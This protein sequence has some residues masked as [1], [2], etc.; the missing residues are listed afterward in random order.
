MTTRLHTL[1]AAYLRAERAAA[2]LHVAS[3][4][5]FE[6][7]P[8]FD[9]DDGVF[10]LDEVRAAIGARISLL[11]RLRQ[12][13]AEV[14]FEVG[15]PL[16]VDDED[17]DIANHVA[18]EP[19][20][21]PGDH[22]AVMDVVTARYCELLD[23]SR[24]LW[25]L[26]FLTGEADGRVVLL[27]RIHH[28]VADGLGG[29]GLATV[30]LDLERHPKAHAYPELP[31]PED[32]PGTV[33]RVRS[34]VVDRTS[35]A[36]RLLRQAASTA[37]HHPLHAARR[38][39]ESIESLRGNGY[40]LFAP[41]SPLNAPLGDQRRLLFVRARLDAFKAIGEAH[42]ATVNDVVLA[43]VA[44]ATRSLLIERGELLTPDAFVKILVPVSFRPHG[45]ASGLGNQV[46]GFLVPLPIG[47]GDPIVRLDTIAG[48]MRT[49]KASGE[50]AAT[51]ALLE[52]ADLLPPVLL[53]GAHLLM[54][55]QPLVNFV[56]TNV[57]GPPCA[58]YAYGAE[59]LD[60]FPIVPL[61]GNLTL[62]VAVLSYNGALNF[63]LT[64]DP[65]VWPDA[66]VFADA[67]TAAVAALA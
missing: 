38:L 26:L 62:G 1:E 61:A 8:F 63:G 11:P 44:A 47:I 39:N 43:V 49:V 18:V 21:A 36:T 42:G 31:A 3:V 15:R 65:E 53:H 58:L 33:E 29:V 27:E 30:L 66:D 56:V 46:A 57:P 32:A 37:W 28:S 34:A 25:H 5:F 52:V 7:G 16:W 54:E 19:I 40:G 22:A 64:V 45:A 48:I 50:E 14:P 35:D 17:F 60:A 12:R 2:P 13:L 55:H 9:D 20:P 67:L 24:P 10:R 4:G 59:M 51:I 23:R 41:H 6:A